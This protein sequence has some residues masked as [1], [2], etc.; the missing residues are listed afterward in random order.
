MSFDWK[1]Y[2]TTITVSPDTVNW[3]DPVTFPR[4]RRHR[5]TLTSE[6]RDARGFPS[7]RWFRCRACGKRKSLTLVISILGAKVEKAR[8][9]LERQ[10]ARDLWGDEGQAGDVRG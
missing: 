5:W 6:R 10:M 9:S 3:P 2:A 8:I 1:E 4:D 7:R